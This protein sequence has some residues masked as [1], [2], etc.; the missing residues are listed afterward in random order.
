M[1][2]EREILRDILTVTCSILKNHFFY[3]TDSL[4]QFLEVFTNEMEYGCGRFGDQAD[5]DI[6]LRLKYDRKARALFTT[7]FASANLREI[8]IDFFYFSEME[9]EAFDNLLPK[10]S[11]VADD[12]EPR[13]Q[14]A[15]Y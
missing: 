6:L 5:E 1:L 11:G 13:N 15:H 9:L 4:K 7:Y 8:L 14:R 2:L 3:D 10:Y 12:I